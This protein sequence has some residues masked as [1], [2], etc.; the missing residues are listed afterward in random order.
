MLPRALVGAGVPLDEWAQ[1]FGQ[2]A[3][4]GSLAVSASAALTTVGILFAFLLIGA[5]L[6][7]RPVGRLVS[8]LGSKADSV[9]KGFP[10]TRSSA[11]EPDVPLLQ[12]VLYIQEQSE[13]GRS[14]S[15]DSEGIEQA[16]KALRQAAFNGDVQIWGK[17]QI[18]NI[19]GVEFSVVEVPIQA[20]FWEKME[21]RSEVVLDETARYQVE[22]RVEWG[23]AGDYSARTIPG[24]TALR[25]NDGQIRAY[26]PKN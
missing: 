13:F 26:W 17:Q 19:T 23:R 10:P 24:Y 25:V 15:D 18:S 11:I 14:I 2:W 21:F 8:G 1:R 3:V 20:E 12:A 22:T 7:W 4:G 5:E 6:W 16:V 9:A